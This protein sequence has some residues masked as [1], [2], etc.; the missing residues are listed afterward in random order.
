MVLMEIWVNA[1]ARANSSPPYDK[2]R[3]HARVRMGKME[4]KL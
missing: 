1:R 4:I 3:K 2:R